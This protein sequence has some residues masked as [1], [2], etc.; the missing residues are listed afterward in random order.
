M[1]SNNHNQHDLDDIIVPTEFRPR[2]KVGVNTANTLNKKKASIYF[3]FATFALLLAFI[4]TARPIQIVVTP[5]SASVD[6]DGG[7]ALPINGRYLMLPGNY[8]ATV[9]ADGYHSHS[10]TVQVGEE[11]R[12]RIDITLNKLAGQVTLTS[13]PSG[14]TVVINGQQQ[15][16]TTLNKLKL[17]AGKHNIK[18]YAERHQPLSADIAVQGMD[19]HQQL[20]FNLEPA[21]ADVLINSSPS[22]A[23]VLIDGTVIGKTPIH[24]EL[25][26]GQ[27]QLSLE[28]IGYKT[29]QSELTVKAGTSQDIGTLVLQRQDGLLQ[30]KT[31]P[32][33]AGV[34]LNGVYRGTSPLDIPL[35]PLKKHTI[36]LVKSGY[37]NLQKTIQLDNTLIKELDVSLKPALAK[38]RFAI[39][40]K[41]AEVLINGKWHDPSQQIVELPSHEHSLEVRKTGYQTHF[42]KFT[43]K[44]GLEQLLTISLRSKEQVRLAAIKPIIKT[45]GGQTMKLLSPDT[46]TLGASRREPGR[47]SN[48]V[49]RPVKL[50][51]L[52]YLSTHEVSNEQFLKFQE[53]HQSGHVEGNSLGSSKQP[54]VK[55]SWELAAQYCNWLSKKDGLEPFYTFSE[56]KPT[57]SNHK[58]T[59]YRLPTEAEWS[60]AARSQ[61]QSP[62]LLKFPWGKSLPPPNNSG[63]YADKNSAFITRRAINN[64]VDK[65]VVTA[66]V[67]SFASNS[68]GLYDMGGNVA[69]WTNDYYG[70]PSSNGALQLNPTG[71]KTG[72][73]RV[74]RGSSWAHGTITELRLSYRDYGNQGRD[75]VGFRLARY[76]E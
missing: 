70:V 50:D 40:P 45:S 10:V 44:P 15:G 67:G 14:A 34:I 22:G 30:L 8:T 74:I 43:P 6:I 41:N 54:V 58:S 5:L 24:A 55:V 59:G 62:Q 20:N 47:R 64:Y 56:G 75:D 63:N 29:V 37:H 35:S 11:H 57:T 38:V 36:T 76:A 2:K 3:L 66:P 23:K 17:E 7:I 26:E 73:S 31:R 18:L 69:E 25:I 42:Q 60:W 13:S 61:S 32:T 53:Q 19:I 4:F 39:K 21:W 65:F 1:S 71:P 9:T 49:L 46:I 12:N 68:M 33:A 16:R 52:F 51:R 72:Q 27:R 28:L 48:E